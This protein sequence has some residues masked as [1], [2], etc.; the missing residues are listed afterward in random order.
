MKRQ[1]YILTEQSVTED[2]CRRAIMDA[3]EGKH[4]R[5]EVA[6][7]LSDIGMRVTLLRDMAINETYSPSPYVECHIKDRPS[8]KER[9]LHKPRFWPDQC[10]HHLV[11]L[12]GN[13]RM[14]RSM[15]YWCLGSLPGRGQARGRRGMAKWLKSD[16]VKTKWCVKG[17][18][19]KCY[20]TVP[21]RV[22]KLR[23]KQMFKD[24][25]YLRLCFAIIES[26]KGGLPI[27]TDED[28]GL[29]LGNY[30]SAWWCNI[31]FEPFDRF[32]R[33]RST[34]RRKGGKAVV[35]VAHYM[36]YI[37]DYVVLGPNKRELQRL[38]KDLMAF[39]RRELNMKVKGNYQVFRVADRGVDVLGYRFYHTHVIMRKRVALSV[40]RCCRK[41][42]KRQ[43]RGRLLSFQLAAR[44]LSL[45]GLVT[46]C[47]S[48]NFA[49]KYVTP[50]NVKAV[51]E[52][53]RNASRIRQH[54]GVS[55]DCSK[56]RRHQQGPCNAS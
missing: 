3:A 56:D 27:Y 30:T 14:L 43:E 54:A 24:P 44:Y 20:P 37:D 10:M 22:L 33:S 9:V 1:G 51:K 4:G 8:G 32:I 34:R 49:S 5:P 15:D 17:D 2:L 21:H 19:S 46:H 28:T 42:R 16:A 38:Q 45:S 35:V 12:L 25:K 11:V 7:T 47:D 48:F 55:G 52:V 41:V 26:F 39:V 13:V 23:L 40:M 18:I 6:A 53:V 36:R 29:P 31:L 50:I